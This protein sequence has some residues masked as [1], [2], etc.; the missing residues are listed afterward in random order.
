V[1]VPGQATALLAQSLSASRTAFS[2]S[3]TVGNNT[4][5]WNPT[6]VV[7]LPSDAVAGLYSGTVTH[8]VA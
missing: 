8:S 4:T 2:A 1:R 5:T 3:A 6:L 7:T